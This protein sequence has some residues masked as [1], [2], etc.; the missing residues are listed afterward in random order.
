[1][2]GTT[3]AATAGDGQEHEHGHAQQGPD[4]A[5]GPRPH[6]ADA[7]AA[8]EDRVADGDDQQAGED[9]GADRLQR[10]GHERGDDVGSPWS[11]CGPLL[12]PSP[13]NSDRGPDLE[14][15]DHQ[16]QAD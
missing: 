15:E 13:P 4:A 3:A 10:G 1:M 12:A 8:A 5:T 2:P 9:R 7:R 14:G 16:G 6:L 11:R